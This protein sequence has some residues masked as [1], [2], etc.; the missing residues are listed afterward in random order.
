MKIFH[1]FLVVAF[2]CL[3]LYSG[4]N[5]HSQV[6]ADD[7]IDEESVPKV[8]NDIGKSRDGSRTDD[9]VVQREEEQIKLDGLNVAQLK[10]L[11]Q[12]A[13]KQEFVAEVNRMMKLIINSLYKNK[14]I[15][16]RELISNASDAL[17]KIRFLALT[18]KN[19]MGDF[20]DLEIKIKVD[21]ENRMLHITDSGIG[22]TKDDLV[23]YLGTIAKSQT[24][25]FLNRF[26]DAQNGE[27]KQSMSDLIGQ[28]GV[29]F[30]SAFLA[31]DKVLVTSKNNQDDQHIWESDSNSFTVYKDPRGNT[32]GRGTTVSLHLKEEAQEFLEESKLKE[33]IAKYS[34]FIN[35][36]I[37]LWTS[38][39]VSEEVPVE[40]EEV[41]KEEKKP[42]A[43]G[44]DAT[45]EEAKEE[46]KE[47]KTKKV[48]KTVWD[49]E[50]MNE[51]KP[52][53]QR[54]PSEVSEQEYIDFYKV[55][56]K[57]KDAPLDS[58]HFVA[59][60][61]VTFKSILFIP[62]SA[63]T[64][65]YQNYNK[66]QETVKM[67]VRRVFIS[68]TYDDILPKFLNFIRGIVD[69]DD[70]PLN[71][72]RETL[73]QNKL[74]KVIKKKLV[75]KVLDMIKKLDE[76]DGE[77]FWKEFGTNLKLGVIEDTTNRVRLAKLLRF[78]SSAN[79]D[80]DKFTTLEKYVE[81]MKEKQEFI[82]YIAGTNRDDLAKSPFVERLLKKGYEVLYLV[83]PIDE[84]CM[85]SLPEFEGKRFQNVAKDGLNIDKSKQ[86][87]ERLK[88]LQKTYEP[89]LNWMKDGP[90]KDKIESVKISTRL[91][92]TPMALV[93]NQYGY[94]GNME[95]ITRAQAYQ[96][97]G[98][99][100]MSNY[101]FGQ[102][103]ILEVNP[104]H[105][106]IK[107]MLRRVEAD[108]SD[109]KAKDLVQ[110]MFESATLRSGYELQNMAGFA[111]RIE[112]MMRSAMNISPSE[113]I[114][115]E[116]DFEEPEEV[117]TKTNDDDNEE[118]K[119]E[120]E[121]KGEHEEL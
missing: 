72:S 104:G 53:W 42:A 34:Q 36:N 41:A 78:S 70:L 26:Q 52:I 91:V 18:D 15:F 7:D 108:S 39:T 93:A 99:D 77:T 14:E 40:G 54:K 98:G 85:Q 9:E 48:E 44:E 23:K 24:S 1:S 74:L 102:K 76:A 22:M 10:E 79:D 30:Y 88:D 63:S 66:K 60:G 86:A 116:P 75:R 29:G 31:A 16:L 38:K 97:S 103:K 58:T 21:K 82:Y 20:D 43:D 94:S 80:K 87:E 89:L 110:L 3:T 65:L 106:L 19:I 13:A 90:L 2:I 33:I 107:E 56:T 101:Y 6:Q 4:W 92:K 117:A 109:Q 73:Q 96:K 17:D 95:R 119:A 45:I 67:Y 11:R 112:S 37:Y 49:W 32:L 25:E 5:I 114:D 69:S 46:P 100:S 105:P 84:Y 113:T 59:E 62:K 118:V 111:D 35:F 51:A 71:V 47:P 64:D 120:S 28:F 57:D 115:E 121:D 83:D 50:L 81:R 68:D 8:D 61:E 55:F 27:N 12:G